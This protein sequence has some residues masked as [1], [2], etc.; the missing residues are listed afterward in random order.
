[1]AAGGILEEG[2]E[3]VIQE[4]EVATQE[5]EVVAIQPSHMTNCQD[6]NRPSSMEIDENLRH[7][8]KNGTSI[9]VSIVTPPKLSTC[10][11][12]SLCSSPLSKEIKFRNGRK[13]NC[14]GP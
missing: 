3:E 11:L 13:S 2:V 14:D 4:A 1:M 7:S 6:S 10:F 8:Y 12:G 5:E 9:G